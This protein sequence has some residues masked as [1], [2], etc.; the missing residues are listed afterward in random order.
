M[1]FR[2]ACPSQSPEASFL[3]FLGGGVRER[4][5]ESVEAAESCW[6]DDFRGSA[7]GSGAA[8]EARTRPSDQCNFSKNTFVD[9]SNQRL[10]A[11]A[12]AAVSSC[13]CNH[14]YRV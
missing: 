5:R 9:S 2:L 12:A 3:F 13:Y 8:S 11:A 7:G 6:G 1:S 14:G 10:E 4:G